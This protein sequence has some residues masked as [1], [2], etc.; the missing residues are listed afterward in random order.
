MPS[1]LSLDWY[2]LE[3]FSFNSSNLSALYPLSIIV[4]LSFLYASSNVMEVSS[5]IAS[6]AFLAPLVKLSSDSTAL[7]FPPDKLANAPNISDKPSLS[8]SLAFAFLSSVL[9]LSFFAS[10]CISSKEICASFSAI[11]LF[12]SSSFSWL[13]FNLSC[14]SSNCFSIEGGIASPYKS[15]NFFLNAVLYSFTSFFVLKAIFSCSSIL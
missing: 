3:I 1:V 14:K 5:I 7:I 8:F 2:S 10:S 6:I 11:F 4:C 9:L 15:L 13:F 12:N